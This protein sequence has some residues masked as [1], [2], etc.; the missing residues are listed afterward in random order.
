MGGIGALAT[1]GTGGKV[2]KKK[3]PSQWRI[4]EPFSA[5]YWWIRAVQKVWRR[6]DCLV[7][8]ADFVEGDRVVWLRRDATGNEG[9]PSLRK[10]YAVA[11]EACRDIFYREDEGE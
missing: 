8:G 7:C 9:H 5:D 1:V 11:H 2:E 4:E 6:H 10:D 3:Y